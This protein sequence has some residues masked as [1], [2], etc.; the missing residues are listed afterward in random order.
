MRMLLRNTSFIL[1]IQQL[2]QGGFCFLALAGFPCASLHAVRA[3]SCPPLLGQPRWQALQR[4]ALSAE[5]SGRA[6]LWSM[7]GRKHRFSLDKHA[8]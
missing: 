5:R 4:R 8:L 1:F 6:A 3:A 7:V 2:E